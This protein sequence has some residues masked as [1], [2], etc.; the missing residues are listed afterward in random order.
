MTD[1]V[2]LELVTDADRNPV[3]RVDVEV[4]GDVEPDVHP[5]SSARTATAN[6]AHV[7][8]AAV[9]ERDLFDEIDVRRRKS[10]VQKAVCGLSNLLL[11]IPKDHGAYAERRNRIADR[12]NVHG[13]QDAGD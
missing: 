5:I 2:S 10:T 7:D 8:D 6:E 11:A 9:L 1:R 4:A 3:E 13:A 12:M